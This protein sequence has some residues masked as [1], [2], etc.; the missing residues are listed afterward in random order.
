MPIINQ[1]AGRL[2]MRLANRAVTKG[3]LKKKHKP[4]EKNIAAPIFDDYLSVKL[5]INYKYI[6]PI[7]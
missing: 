1:T 7:R 4:I 6:K 2:P 3:M 5:K